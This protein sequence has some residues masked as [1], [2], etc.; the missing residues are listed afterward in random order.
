[1]TKIKPFLLPV[2]SAAVYLAVM[3]L[4]ETVWMPGYLLKSIVKIMLTAVLVGIACAVQKKSPQEVIFLR[5]MKPAKTLFLV[6]GIM[7]AGVFLGF[8]LLKSQLDLTLIRD[9]LAEK[10]GLTKQNCL[11]VFGYIIVVNSFLEEAFFRGF[12]G[13]SLPKPWGIGLAA[14]AFA[15]YHIGILDTW[16]SPVLLV[17]MTAGLAAVGAVLQLICDHYD[18]LKASWLVHGCANLAINTIGCYIFF[19]IS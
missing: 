1:M 2:L 7:F 16:V 14:V 19:T 13:H 18:S 12:L 6:M 4:V 17:L 11:F 5:Q 3:A 15:V 9:R 8:L 10:E